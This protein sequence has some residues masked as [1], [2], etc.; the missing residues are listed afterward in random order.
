MTGKAV[1]TELHR[2][3]DVS[4]RTSTVLRLAQERGLE[5]Q[6][7]S[8]ERF[9]EKLIL[10]KPL[11]D[12]G[13]VLATFSLFQKILDC[14]E[15]FE[16]AAFEGVED[17]WNEGTRKAELRFSP[18]FIT[19]FNG[20]AWE[21]VLDGFERGVQKALQKYP[22]MKVGLICI[23]SREYGLEGAEKTVEF[24]LKNQNRF[25]G[26]DL[27]GD[28]ATYP[29]PIFEAPFQAALRHGAKITIHSGEASGPENVWQA[30]QRLGAR[31]I[32]HGVRSIQ[33][34]MLVQYLAKHQ[35]CLEICPTSNW[36]TQAVPTLESHP[37]PE[38][39]RAGVPVCINTD[40][41][42]VFGVTLP[43]EIDVCVRKMG[44]TPEEISE[45]FRHA[46]LHSF[47]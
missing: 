32:G 36:L 13:T 40:D 33:D 18:A 15:V 28:E 16:Q 22:K 4:L 2:H 24:F 7:T 5:A 42:G 34:P 1:P 10:R 26:L 41:P 21:E 14:P 9:S 17:C 44:L 46:S 25:I 31:R 47:L 20:L 37:L 6:S 43:H 11:Q 39:L 8:L 3:L 35:I 30:I 45:T 23:A 38:L 12:L 29:N 27:A 19:E